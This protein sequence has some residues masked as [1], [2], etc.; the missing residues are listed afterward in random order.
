MLILFVEEEKEKQAIECTEQT[1]D[2][3]ILFF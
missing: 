3:P 1:L 2:I